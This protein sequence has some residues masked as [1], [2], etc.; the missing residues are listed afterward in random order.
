MR[1]RQPS[2]LFLYCL[3][4]LVSDSAPLSTPSAPQTCTYVYQPIT[5][6]GDPTGNQM[7]CRN[8]QS[9]QRFFICDQKSCEGTRKCTNCVSQ[10]TNVSVNSIECAKYYV[11]ENQKT[12]N[13]WTSGDEQFTCYDQCTGAAVCSSCTLDE[14][15]P[16]ISNCVSNSSPKHGSKASRASSASTSNPGGVSTWLSWN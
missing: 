12:T 3:L 9:P 14:Q 4:A 8:A 7:T 2:H 13:C 5:T 10:T 16:S 15:T 6:S 1:S 11:D